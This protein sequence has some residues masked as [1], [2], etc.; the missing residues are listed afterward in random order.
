[1][2]GQDEETLKGTPLD[3]GFDKTSGQ[4]SKIAFAALVLRIDPSHQYHLPGLGIDGGLH[5]HHAAPPLTVDHLAPGRTQL[6]HGALDVCAST[7][8]K[9]SK[10]HKSRLHT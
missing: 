1:M 8:F 6:N 10:I 7:V 5:T 2:P 3:T 9:P 4:Q